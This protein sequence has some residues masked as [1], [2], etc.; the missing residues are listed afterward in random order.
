M[1]YVKY[2]SLKIFHHMMYKNS[3]FQRIKIILAQNVCQNLRWLFTGLFWVKNMK[4]IDI[5]KLSRITTRSRT[6]PHHLGF[7]KN[8]HHSIV[9]F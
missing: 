7:H 6:V 5:L 9:T 2:Q 8:L 1:F 3:I 4:W